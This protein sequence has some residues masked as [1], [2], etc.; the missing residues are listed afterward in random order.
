MVVVP[1][2]PP[3]SLGLSDE[4]IS[5]LNLQCLLSAHVRLLTFSHTAWLVRLV[6]DVCSLH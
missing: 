2:L 5:F 1:Y 6:V 3:V 4:I